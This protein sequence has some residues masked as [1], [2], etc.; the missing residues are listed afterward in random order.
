MI[1]VC[2][3]ICNRSME[4]ASQAEWPKF[5]FCSERCKTIDLGRWLGEAYG[6]P[7]ESEEESEGDRSDAETDIP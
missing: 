2:C 4:G 6:I 7:R 5:P 1:K 3:P